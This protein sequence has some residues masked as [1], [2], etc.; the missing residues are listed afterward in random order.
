MHRERV[1]FISPPGIGKCKPGSAKSWPQG[2]SSLFVQ[3]LEMLVALC[4]TLHTA[5]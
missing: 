1:S 2:E 4:V 3:E 5:S